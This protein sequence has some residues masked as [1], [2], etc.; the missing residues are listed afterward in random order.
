[1]SKNVQLIFLFIFLILI[2]VLILNN[3][4]LLGYINPYVYITF[5][6][7]YPIQKNRFYFLT[8]SFLIGLIIDA[9]SNSGGIHAAASLFIAYI[10]LYLFKKIFQ[11][12]ETEY[13]LFDLKEETFGKIFNYTVILTLIH[14]FILFSF[15]NFSFSNIKHIL[16]NTFLSAIFTLLLFYLGNYIFSSKKQ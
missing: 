7:L 4:L 1:M 15:A 16:I 13:E 3:I 14:H 8:F 5:I 2:Q 6:F 10:R 9:F 11:K 12:S